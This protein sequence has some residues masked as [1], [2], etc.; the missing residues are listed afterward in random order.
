MINKHRLNLM[1]FIVIG[2]FIESLQNRTNDKNF[3]VPKHIEKMR[4]GNYL[5]EKATRINTD[6]EK[7]LRTLFN[8]LRKNYKNKANSFVG[9]KQQWDTHYG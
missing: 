6:A 9:R 8:K 4:I 5:I 1:L 2:L 7:P 3:Y